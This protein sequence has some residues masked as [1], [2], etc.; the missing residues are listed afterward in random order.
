MNE[1]QTSALALAQRSELVPDVKNME[2]MA[3]HLL[4]SGLFPNVKNVAGALTVMEYGRELGLPAVCSLQTMVIIKGKLAMEAKAML[5][6]AQ[7]RAGVTWKVMELNDDRCTM[8]FMRPGFENVVVTFT[9]LEA[10]AAGLL[11]KDNWRL[12]R[13]DML[14]ARCSSRGV[15]RIAP[16]AVLGL[17]STEEMRDVVEIEKMG[18]KVPTDKE[19]DDAKAKVV[20]AEAEPDVPET[21]EAEGEEELPVA[22]GDAADAP[23]ADEKA[24]FEDEP[25]TKPEEPKLTPPDDDPLRKVVAAIMETLEAERISAPIFRDW[26]AKQGP[27]MNRVFVGRVGKAVSFQKGNPEDVKYLAG[28][29]PKAIALFRKEQA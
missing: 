13:Q 8:T 25:E 29:L 17:Y 1:K 28:M 3:K 7:N 22:D 23:G 24:P 14:F 26:L 20:D 2:I 6:I 15:R 9:A 19:V 5:A 16:D 18:L 27:K 4:D 21:P 10:K 11:D 12:Y